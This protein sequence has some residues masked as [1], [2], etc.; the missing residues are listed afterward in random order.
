MPLSPD[1]LQ[2]FIT[3]TDSNTA[4]TNGGHSNPG[5][6]DTS[7]HPFH[8]K[9]GKYHTDNDLEGGHKVT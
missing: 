4:G 9:E 2:S 1:A 6:I 7:V 5:I 8:S 3:Q